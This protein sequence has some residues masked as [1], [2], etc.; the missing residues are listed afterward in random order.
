VLAQTQLE[1]T[2]M[3]LL[4]Y[5]SKWSRYRIRLKPE[6]IKEDDAMIRDSIK[7]AYEY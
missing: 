6:D 1:D 3:D 2:G 4:D 7:R 5:D